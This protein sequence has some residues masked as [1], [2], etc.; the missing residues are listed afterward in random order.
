[1]ET[2]TSR[3]VWAI[4][5]AIIG[6]VVSIVIDRTVLPCFEGKPRLEVSAKR[7]DRGVAMFEV[8][9]SGDAEV[10][11]VWLTARP[12]AV[13]GA[14]VDIQAI[15]L[16]ETDVDANCEFRLALSKF[17]SEPSNGMPT[18]LNTESASLELRCDLIN[19]GEKWSARLGFAEREAVFGILVHVKYPGTSENLYAR[20][21]DS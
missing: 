21:Q 3:L 11:D 10:R 1:M 16:E 13:F 2:I 19:P 7:L 6:S 8:L 12:A 20:F 15:K 5:G 17:R 9:N 4:G 18:V 14:G